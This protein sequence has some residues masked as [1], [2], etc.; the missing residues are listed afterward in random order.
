M[1]IAYTEQI[2]GLTI[3]TGVDKKPIDQVETIKNINSLLLESAEMQAL[4]T[5]NNQ[6]NS[7]VKQNN[8]LIKNEIAIIKQVQIEKNTENITETDLSLQQKQIIQKY[9]NTKDYN[10]AQIEELKKGLPQLNENLKAKKLQL[11]NDNAVYQE[12]AYNQIN[13]TDVQYNDFKIKLVS[14]CNSNKKQYLINDGNIIEDNRGRTVWIKNV[15][16]ISRKLQFLT[17]IKDTLEIWE[18]ELTEEQKT[19]IVNQVEADRI[20]GLT[21]EE[22]TAEKEQLINGLLREAAIMKSE[23]EIQSDPNA[24]QKSQDWYSAEVLKVEEKYS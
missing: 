7:Y 9:Q 19:E 16:W 13:S 23:L 2:D 22:K 21:E 14:I 12:T 18:D 17:D 15:K 1:Y 6:I 3:I 10:N 4:N 24:L 11:I 8:V 5:R 20:A